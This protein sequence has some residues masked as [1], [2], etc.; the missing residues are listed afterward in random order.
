VFFGPIADFVRSSGYPFAVAGP[1]GGLRASSGLV[2]LSAHPIVRQERSAFPDCAWTDCFAR[3]GVM[4]VWAEVPGLPTPITV[5]NT[6]LQA[7]RKYDSTRRLQVDTL[8]SFLDRI[9]AERRFTVF[10]G[11]FNMRQ[12]ESSYDYLLART[13]LHDVG[14]ICLDI[15]EVCHGGDAPPGAADAVWA[16]AI[17]RHFTYPTPATGAQLRPVATTWTFRDE[18]VAGQ[19]LSDH[20]GYEVEYEARW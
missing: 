16:H 20:W 10:G 4:A 11:D 18:T 6:H 3:K 14:R 5:L 13:R 9:G 17:D 7:W 1:E 19:P 2:I 12:G 15:G 8:A